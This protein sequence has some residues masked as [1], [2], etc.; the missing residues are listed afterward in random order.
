MNLRITSLALALALTAST[1]WGHGDE[2]HKPSQVEPGRETAGAVLSVAAEAEDAVAALE[3]F[4]A[5]LSA[6]DLS[7][8]GA[9]LDPSVLILES[10]GAERTR[11]EYLGGHAK[12]DA[13]FLKAAH[14]TLQ[15]RVAQASGDL[16]WVGSESEIHASRGDKMLMISSTETAVLRKT[17]QGWKIVHIHWSSR[18]QK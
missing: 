13:E 17:A 6:D 5:A 10:G 1:A 3:R 14:T 12:H 11:D 16:V 2:K 9:E 7:A 15:R 4:S 18:A 8:A